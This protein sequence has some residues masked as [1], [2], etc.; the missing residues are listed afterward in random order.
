MRVTVLGCGG[1]SGVPLIGNRWYA[2]DPNNPRNRR[3]RS[4]ILVETA[5]STLLVDT[6]PDLRE[7]LLDANVAR[8]DAVLYTHAHADHT[9]G[10]DELREV[11]R[12]MEQA[13]P[14]WGDAQ[15][16]EQLERRFDYAF[17]PLEDWAQGFYY[18]P[19]LESHLIEGPFT[20]AGVPVVPFIQNHGWV[21]S[22][23]FRMGALAYS[24]DV[25]ALDE[26]AF[27]ALEGVEVWLVDCVREEPHP[28]HAHLELTLSWIARLRPRLAVLIHMG[29]SLDYEALRQRLPSGVVPAYDGM[30]IDVTP[31]Q[32]R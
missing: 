3:R 16:L 12:L 7:Q 13:I 6:S 29:P 19:V 17:R 25:L 14:V 23:G 10:L 32:A 11:C 20:A 31:A 27:A 4:S 8:V 24:T 5:A 18:R 28:V 9:H 15:T 2:C 21:T 1:S 26:A 30:V 22:L